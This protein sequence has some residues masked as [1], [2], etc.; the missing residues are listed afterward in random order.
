MTAVSPPPSESRWLIVNGLNNFVRHI[1]L[2]QFVH[3]RLQVQL[4]FTL[5]VGYVHTA[6]CCQLMRSHTQHFWSVKLTQAFLLILAALLH[7][8][9][10]L[11]NFTTQM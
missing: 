11:T 2:N 10:A 9:E 3:S 6:F 8:V 5:A 7:S 4:P 1:A